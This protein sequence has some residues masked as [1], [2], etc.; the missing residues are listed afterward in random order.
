MS[1]CH[2]FFCR[3]DSFLDLFIAQPEVF[4]ER[5]CRLR[6]NLLFYFKTKDFY[7]DSTT[8]A[9]AADVAGVIVLE[10]FDIQVSSPMIDIEPKAAYRA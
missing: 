5:F 2:A 9:T 6:G 1:S 3:Q 8:V 4:V 10:R 7:K